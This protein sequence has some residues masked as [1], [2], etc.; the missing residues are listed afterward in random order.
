MTASKPAPPKPAGP[1]PKPDGPSHPQPTGPPPGRLADDLD[2]ADLL[3]RCV[4]LLADN[5]DGMD[6]ADRMQLA[7]SVR[8]ARRAIGFALT[9]ARQHLSSAAAVADGPDFRLPRDIRCPS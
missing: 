3:L 1:G 2:H 9:P 8:T 4:E 5:L 7:S 6:P